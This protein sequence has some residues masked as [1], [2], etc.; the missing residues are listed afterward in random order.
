MYYHSWQCWPVRHNLSVILILSHVKANKYC[1]QRFHKFTENGKTRLLNGNDSTKQTPPQ[2]DVEM[3]EEQLPG[4][5]KQN[6]KGLLLNR[7][8]V[9]DLKYFASA[10]IPLLIFLTVP[11]TSL[12]SSYLI[13]L[14][15]SC[16]SR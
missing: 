1:D 15:Q 16:W 14:Q 6:P 11:V 4:K 3:F 5:S 9:A 8:I 7:Q 12:K 10:I 13:C 2:I